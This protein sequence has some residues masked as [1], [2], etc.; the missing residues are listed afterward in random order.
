MTSTPAGV[1]LIPDDDTQQ[2]EGVDE[3]AEQ[4][5]VPALSSIPVPGVSLVSPKFSPVKGS[6]SPGSVSVPLGGVSGDD[7]TESP[8]FVPSW[9]LRNN[10]RLSVRNNALEFSRHAFPSAAVG[11]ME[12]M[13][14]TPESAMG[15]G[16]VS[17]AEVDAGK[18]NEGGD[19]DLGESEVVVVGNEVTCGE[20]DVVEDAPASCATPLGA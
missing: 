12:A 2:S 4:P 15:Q 3:A 9:D 17:V 1:V 11:D 16:I 8:V 7:S 19:D 13:E 14:G 20:D 6:S 18:G 5:V 10:S